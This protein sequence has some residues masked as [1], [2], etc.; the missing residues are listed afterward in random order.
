MTNEQLC[1]EIKEG[2]AQPIELWLQLKRFIR[3][4]ALRY[5]KNDS[6][7]L[8]DDLM[9][10]SYCALLSAIKNYQDDGRA[11]FA[12]YASFWING[13]FANY[14]NTNGVIRLP[15]GVAAR[16]R[17]FNKMVSTFRRDYGRDPTEAEVVEMFGVSPD[18]LR[19]ESLLTTQASLDKPL[20]EDGED[21]LAD[22]IEAPE[23]IEKTVIDKINADELQTKLWEIVDTL[24]EREALVIKMY[25]RDGLTQQQCGEAL[26]VTGTMAGTI[27]DSA[28]RKLRSR[29]VTEQLEP[30]LDD[31]R[32]SWGTR[33]GRFSPTEYAAIKALN[34]LN[35]LKSEGLF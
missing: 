34:Y 12:H 23:D 22:M 27:R 5:V 26:S 1:H 30:Y 33:R 25:Y 29:K 2:R 17:S 28:L 9:Q 3:K 7:P 32:Y 20:T 16:V 4:I 21:T 14:V 15:A 19:S 10:E 6:D 18:Q 24:P 8:L 13:R 31:L 11:T 35:K